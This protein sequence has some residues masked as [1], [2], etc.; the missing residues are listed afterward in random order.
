MLDQTTK[1]DVSNADYV[2]FVVAGT[3]VAGAYHCSTCG[4]GVTV[5]AEL[6]SCPMCAGTTWE[7][8]DWSPFSQPSRLH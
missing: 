7:V 4:Y 2:E 6:P 3:E 8:R 5:H 1:A